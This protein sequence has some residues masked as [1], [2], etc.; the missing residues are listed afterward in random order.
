MREVA[1]NRGF[2][3]ASW[4]SLVNMVSIASRRRAATDRPEES[5]GP[6]G[7]A[8]KSLSLGINGSNIAN[9]EAAN[10][11]R[12]SSRRVPRDSACGKIPKADWAGKREAAST[13]TFGLRYQRC[14]YFVTHLM[15]EETSLR[16]VDNEVMIKSYTLDD[17][18]AGSPRKWSYVDEA[19]SGTTC[20]GC[21]S[22]FK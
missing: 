8:A 5:N 11:L 10:T 4:R 18:D 3:V 22:S 21:Q 19:M 20:D 15:K 6:A 17:S 13:S 14:T 16:R 1:K 7:I 2:R 9:E 12:Y